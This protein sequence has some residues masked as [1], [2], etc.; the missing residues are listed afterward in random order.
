[1]GQNGLTTSSCFAPEVGESRDA[2][3]LQSV[4]SLLFVGPDVMLL[5][6]VC[7]GSLTVSGSREDKPCKL[8]AE[9]RERDL[10][11]VA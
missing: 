1:M 2:S 5:W 7:D 9:V 10:S 11:Q 4:L 6:D 3:T 8:L